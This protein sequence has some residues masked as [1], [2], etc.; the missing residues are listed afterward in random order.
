MRLRIFACF[1]AASCF[2]SAALASTSPVGAIPGQFSVS[3]TGA[4]TYTIPI[5]VPPGVAGMEPKLSLT[6]NSQGGNGL[7]GVGWSLSGLSAITRC[8][9]TIIQGG[10]SGGIEYSTSDKYCQDGQ[11]LVAVSGANGSDGAEYCTEIES[12]TKVI[13]Y[14][15]AGNGPAWFKARIFGVVVAFLCSLTCIA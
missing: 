3:E 15:T 5:A 1:I 2:G 9:R 8:T 4:A 7:L 10:A 13:S 14:G 6:Y 11:R 12:F